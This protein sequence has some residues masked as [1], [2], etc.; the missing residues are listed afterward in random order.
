MTKLSEQ[1]E[2]SCN[3]YIKAFEKK[4]MMSFEFWVADN[5]GGVAGFGD[6]FFDFLDIK[7]DVD[8]E[9]PPYRI[10]EWSEHVLENQ[11]KFINYATYC[12]GLRFEDIE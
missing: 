11:P 10:I 5:V 8:T 1:Y 7:Y 9:Q 12:K 3:E 4:Q 6:L 2:K